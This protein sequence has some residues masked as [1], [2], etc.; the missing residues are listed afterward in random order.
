MVELIYHYY[1]YY[2][3]IINKYNNYINNKNFANNN[4]KYLRVIDIEL[5]LL[6]FSKTLKAS[7]SLIPGKSLSYIKMKK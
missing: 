4:K 6:I 5:R 1:N 3:I 2:Y 7:I